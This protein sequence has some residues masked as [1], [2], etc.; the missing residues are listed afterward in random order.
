LP[1]RIAGHRDLRAENVFVDGSG[2]LVVG[3][4]GRVKF[5][6]EYVSEYRDRM[7]LAGV[8]VDEEEAVARLQHAEVTNTDLG[9][10]NRKFVSSAMANAIANGSR[11]YNPQQEDVYCCG[12][13]LATMCYN[14]SD[15]P[16]GDPNID[17]AKIATVPNTQTLI[18]T[19]ECLVE[20]K[21]DIYLLEDIV[22]G[23]AQVAAGQSGW[24]EV[25]EN[26]RRRWDEN[27]EARQMYNPN[28]PNLIF[29]AIWDSL[30]WLR[31][32]RPATDAELQAAM[33]PLAGAA[34][35]GPT[36]FKMQGPM[37]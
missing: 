19:H 11:H 25:K 20:K 13:L 26:A 8:D 4:L 17:R 30:E 15:N 16:T 7:R 22:E 10:A 5:R 37:P 24:D 3:D 1:R 23:K 32:E 12:T 28:G 6:D 27:D 36:S 35:A 31:T 2:R 9:G 29:D 14:R 33:A 21:P 18:R 34:A